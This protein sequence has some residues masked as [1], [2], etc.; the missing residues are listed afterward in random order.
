MV[1]I[2]TQHKDEEVIIDIL[3]QDTL[4]AAIPDPASHTVYIVLSTT[5]GGAALDATK[6]PFTLEDAP[7][8]RFRR[9][10]SPT[11][12]ASVQELPASYFYNIWSTKPGTIPVHRAKGKFSLI[13]SIS[14]P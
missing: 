7:T 13:E 1:D 5:P 2:N 4:G 9:V 10:L 11:D 8:A 12:L 3:I 6:F 14:L